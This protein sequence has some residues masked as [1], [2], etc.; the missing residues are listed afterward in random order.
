MRS[1]TMTAITFDYDALKHKH[2]ETRGWRDLGKWLFGLATIGLGG[3]YF[4]GTTS[5]IP[6]GKVGLRRKYNGELELLPP[7]RHS[8]FPWE[9]YVCE[10]QSI[11]GSDLIV[12]GPYKIVNVHTNHYAVTYNRAVLETLPAGVYLIEDPLHTVNPKF[13]S[14]KRETKQL[15]TIT[16]Y[17]NDIVG[18]DINADVQYQ[19]DDPKLAIQ[20]IKD[21][22]N[23]INET[24]RITICRLVAEHRLREFMP[25]T[26]EISKTHP[27]DKE[28]AHSDDGIRSLIE[29][30]SSSIREQLKAVGIRLLNIGITSLTIKNNTL[31]H[32]LAQGAVVNTQVASK[33]VTAESEAQVRLVGAQAEA[34]SI[35]VIAEA[36]AEAL[37]SHGKAI[38]DIAK[39]LQLDPQVIYEG[40][41]RTKMVS[42]AHNPHLFLADKTGQLPARVLTINT[43]ENHSIPRQ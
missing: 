10:P 14:T 6:E 19:I 24:A 41:Q 22:E 32:E 11:Y 9:E 40:E 27:K 38:C 31:A 3:F 7:G 25:A 12:L 23:S 26:A 4:W 20:E 18:L 15:N 43:E 1:G 33:M 29:D 13:I 28:H 36:Q 5:V 30:I 42:Q 8:N 2:A 21:I 34:E 17:T 37:R 35:R 16:A 39:E